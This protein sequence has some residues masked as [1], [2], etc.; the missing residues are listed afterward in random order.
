MGPIYPP[1]VAFTQTGAVSR[2][3]RTH[4][5]EPISLIQLKQLNMT[6]IIGG[7]Y[8]EDHS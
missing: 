8:Y 4:R 6:K 3:E 7:Y 5:P 2:Q 1:C